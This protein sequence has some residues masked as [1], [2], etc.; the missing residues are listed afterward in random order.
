MV[1]F[2][3][4]LFLVVLFFSVLHIL[5]LVRKAE[6]E[7]RRSWPF[8][9]FE[10]H[11]GDFAVVVVNLETTLLG[12]CPRGHVMSS[13]IP[14]SCEGERPFLFDISQCNHV[15]FPRRAHAHTHMRTSVRKSFEG[16]SGG[17]VEEGRTRTAGARDATPRKR[18]I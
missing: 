6:K 5:W 15:R 3:F 16:K 13:R 12:V 8:F 11:V 2:L 18:R 9:C 4:L 17:T 7:R 14:S 10:S 1:L